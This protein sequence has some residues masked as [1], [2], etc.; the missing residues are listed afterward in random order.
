MRS[1]DEKYVS[2]RNWVCWRSAR[3][4]GSEIDRTMDGIWNSE[5]IYTN[6]MECIDIPVIFVSDMNDHQENLTYLIISFESN[7]QGEFIRKSIQYIL[8]AVLYGIV[9][10]RK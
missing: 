8:K 6:Y 4:R 1:M 5:K 9:F 3:M 7:M 10:G 2:H